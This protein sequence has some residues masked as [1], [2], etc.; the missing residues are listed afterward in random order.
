[1]LRNF[2]SDLVGFIALFPALSHLELYFEERDE[3]KRFPQ[4]SEILYVL[5]L[6]AFCFACVDG[7]ET[8]LARLLLRHKDT[9]KEIAFDCI[10]IIAEEGS[11]QSLIRTIRNTLAVENFTMTYCT[12]SGDDISDTEGCAFRAYVLKAGITDSGQGQAGSQ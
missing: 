5:N 11:W 6:E 10:D 2:G 12:L 7:T 3:H 9:L 1:M 4:I 8:E